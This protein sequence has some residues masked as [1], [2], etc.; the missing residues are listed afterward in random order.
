MAYISKVFSG[1]Y[2]RVK[3]LKKTTNLINVRMVDFGKESNLLGCKLINDT[4]VI[5]IAK[6]H[7]HVK[8]I[9]KK[10]H[11]QANNICNY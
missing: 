3:E 4:D 8:R 11:A 10:K 9:K 7:R 2:P 5:Q 1:L 6:L